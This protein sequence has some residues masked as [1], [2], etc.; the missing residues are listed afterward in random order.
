MYNGAIGMTIEQGG[1]GR[2]GIGVLTA[3]GDTLT[4]KDRIAHHHTTGLAITEVTSQNV[5]NLLTQFTN[6][7][8]DNRHA[9]RG[10]YK[11][12]VLKHSDKNGN[13]ES[14]L[15][16]LDKNGIQ[17]GS[18]ANRSSLRGFNYQTGKAES[19]STDDKDII[20]SSS[21]PK[22]VLAQILF[23]PNPVLAD[24]ITYDITSWALPYAYG[25]QAYAVENNLEQIG[26]AHV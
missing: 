14:L 1:S 13:L 10:S 25:V 16:L 22:S 5:D 19:F 8:K 3:E 12:F 11:S 18:A 4:L 7:F 15:D 9:P 21:Q 17:Y 2:A 20:I 23:E 6:Y 26:R 24:S